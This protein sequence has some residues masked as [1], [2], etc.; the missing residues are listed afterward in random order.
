MKNFLTTL[1]ASV[2]IVA[3]AGG[4]ASKPQPA[5]A[6]KGVCPAKGASCCVAKTQ[7]KANTQQ[8]PTQSSQCSTTKSSN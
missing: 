3:L 4:C 1:A 5:P 2:A 6:G 7:C 8:C